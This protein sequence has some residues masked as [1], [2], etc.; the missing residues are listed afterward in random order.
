MRTWWQ[1]LLVAMRPW[2]HPE[3]TQPTVDTL[4]VQRDGTIW[5]TPW[6]DRKR[7]RE[8]E[9]RGYY[10]DASAHANVDCR[11]YV[12]AASEDEAMKLVRNGFGDA[13]YEDIEFLDITDTYGVEE[14]HP[15]DRRTA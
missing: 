3:W 15:R 14:A 8:E 5:A 4:K 1:R 6:L 11:Y 12:E 7:E 10:V 2:P 9:I 13:I